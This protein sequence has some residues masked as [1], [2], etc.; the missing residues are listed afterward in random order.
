MNKSLEC[1]ARAQVCFIFYFRYLYNLLLWNQVQMCGFYIN[2][3]LELSF[4]SWKVPYVYSGDL[5]VLQVNGP[6]NIV[7]IQIVKKAGL[8]SMYI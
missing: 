7:H 4:I 2:I 1:S 6:D 8:Y 3:I 5:H